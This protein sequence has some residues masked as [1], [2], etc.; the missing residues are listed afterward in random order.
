MIHVQRAKTK[1]SSV[2]KRDEKDEEKALCD[3]GVVLKRETCPVAARRLSTCKKEEEKC[4]N[5]S[6]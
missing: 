1:E 6:T 5:Y 3:N 4:A 2:D